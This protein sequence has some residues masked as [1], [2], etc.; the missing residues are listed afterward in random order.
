MSSVAQPTPAR[1]ATITLVERSSVYEEGGGFTSEQ[2]LVQVN[3]GWISLRELLKRGSVG[4]VTAE[5]VE[6][7]DP[8]E[9]S[10]QSSDGPPPQVYYL[11]RVNLAAPAGTLLRRRVW[12]PAVN[13]NLRV[14]DYLLKGDLFPRQQR[15]DRDFE[16]LKDGR[17]MSA[18]EAQERRQRPNDTK[19]LPAPR[20]EEVVRGAAG[21]L[22]ALERAPGEPAP[23]RSSVESTRPRED[24]PSDTGISS[25]AEVA[26]RRRPRVR[27]TDTVTT[28]GR[29][30]KR[31]AG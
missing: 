1:L 11:Y 14:I 9:E 4:G 25:P 24:T 8:T 18:R 28:D 19:Q 29:S 3:D 6:K 17:L 26:R 31:A 2:W 12:R 7:D 21:L 15:T 5:L 10:F 20:R 22:A 13:R 27:E 23:R 30:R 16:L